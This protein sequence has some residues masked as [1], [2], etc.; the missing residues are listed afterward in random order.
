MTGRR[1]L[2]GEAAIC[3]LVFANACTNDLADGM[4]DSVVGGIITSGGVHQ[5]QS[6]ASLCQPLAMKL[7]PDSTDGNARPS[8][9]ISRNARKMECAALPMPVQ[10]TAHLARKVTLT[11][12]N[13][14]TMHTTRQPGQECAKS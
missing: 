11:D 3:P 7:P 12:K 6:A 4:I 5:Q 9:M 13:T 10:N 2:V 8:Q 14:K 1:L